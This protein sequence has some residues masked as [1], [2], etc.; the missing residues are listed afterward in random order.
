MD[1]NWYNFNDG[2]VTRTTPSHVLENKTAAY[3]LFY[4]RRDY[5]PEKF[6][7]YTPVGFRRE[8]NS[9]NI[10]VDFNG[11]SFVKGS[12]KSI[13]CN[14]LIEAL[15]ACLKDNNVLC[16]ANVPWIRKQLQIRYANGNS[17]VKENTYLKLK[18]H[19]RDV[20]DLIG[21]SA[22]S[23]GCDSGNLIHADR[24][25]VTSVDA[26]G[27]IIAERHGNGFIELFVL[28]EGNEHFVPLLH[29]RQSRMS[30]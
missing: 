11:R 16:V 8:P 26:N 6:T 20:I 14:C 30:T 18:N 12:S 27:C 28:N 25:S 21:L 17:I 4:L 9:L 3:V 19:W 24:F 2:E 1:G 29:S 7:S 5:R 10:F 13:G 22:K 23:H 15:L